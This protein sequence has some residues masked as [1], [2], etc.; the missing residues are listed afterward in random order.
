MNTSVARE[1]KENQK[2]VSEEFSKPQKRQS[3]AVVSSGSG[4]DGERG[5]RK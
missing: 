2:R 1:T 3:A 5:E 4:C